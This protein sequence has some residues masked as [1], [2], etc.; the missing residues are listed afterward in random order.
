M[1]KGEL[2]ATIAASAMVMVEVILM[3]TTGR[4]FLRYL[5]RVVV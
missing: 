2:T 1:M 5:E 4:K 3:L